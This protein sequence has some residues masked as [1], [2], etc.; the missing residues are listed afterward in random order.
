MT[1]SQAIILSATSLAST[2]PV[3]APNNEQQTFTIPVGSVSYTPPDWLTTNLPTAKPGEDYANYKVYLNPYTLPAGATQY[4]AKTKY[5]SGNDETDTLTFSLDTSNTT[6]GL[7]LDSSDPTAPFLKGI[8]PS[9]VSIC[10]V[11]V[12]VTSKDAGV[13]DQPL[14]SN[15]KQF[16]VGSNAPQWS[17][18][19][20]LVNI[21]YST[22]PTLLNFY[23]MTD[24][25][26]DQTDVTLD[27]PNLVTQ[28][29][30]AGIPIQYTTDS[31]GIYMVI[32]TTQADIDNTKSTGGF[33]IVAASKKDS[34]QTNTGTFAVNVTAAMTNPVPINTAILSS[35]AVNQEYGDTGVNIN[36]YPLQ[37]HTPCLVNGILSPC[38]TP[39]Q[40]T[41]TQENLSTDTVTFTQATGNNSCNDWATVKSDGSIT[42]KPTQ[43]VNC[44]IYFTV[45]SAR[46][47]KTGS[48]QSL[49][50]P[51]TGTTPQWVSPLSAESIMFDDTTTGASTLTA[52]HVD[53]NL[54]I[55]T[56]AS[57]PPIIDFTIGAN[58]HSSGNWAIVQQTNNS[59]AADYLH[60]Y[61]IRQVNG[62]TF[63]ASHVS[64]AKV[65][66]EI[67]TAPQV[68]AW[69]SIGSSTPKDLNIK[70]VADSTVAF[71]FPTTTWTATVGGDS[72]ASYYPMYNQSNSATANLLQTKTSGG[73][74]VSGD[75]LTMDYT[76]EGLPAQ[77]NGNVVASSGNCSG[78]NWIAYVNGGSSGKQ[79][80]ISIPS[81]CLSNDNDPG[82]YTGTQTT[83]RNLTSA[84]KG[85]ATQKQATWNFNNN[86]T[87]Q[88]YASPTFTLGSYNINMPFDAISDTLGGINL[89]DYLYTKNTDPTFEQLGISV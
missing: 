17:A 9:G 33:T 19:P 47:G 40:I 35:S 89:T 45:T 51:T 56:S 88:I 26:S 63:D 81:S 16:S 64:G 87:V 1:Q 85:G 69:N 4:I 66:D 61:L 54:L 24:I 27:I 65:G 79:A 71:Y 18:T 49:Y 78:R 20:M 83:L 31:S 11:A 42:G 75:I 34:T 59:S 86:L 43:A 48:I 80:D 67:E 76:N 58:Q 30:S 32:N 14:L 13:T 72:N 21:T 38:L 68:T 39:T 70:I 84:A 7:S 62:G 52:P 41:P 15:P 6:C 73:T 25:T 53:L 12:K 55:Q 36:P 23:P 22:N 28:L 2:N 82:S 50:I 3:G 29:P 10:A 57:N 60:F 74:L 37:T 8:I 77:G 44:Y 5:G 46:N